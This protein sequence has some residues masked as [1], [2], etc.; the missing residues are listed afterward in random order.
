MVA[1]E[2]QLG[3]GVVHDV[4]NL[5]A[6]ELVQDGYGNG[7]VGQCGQEGYGPLT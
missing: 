2:E 3:V 4:V 1:Y 5:V 7:S 6:G